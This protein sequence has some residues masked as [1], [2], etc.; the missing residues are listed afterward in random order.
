MLCLFKKP[1]YQRSRLPV[2]GRL[3]GNPCCFPS[4]M[5]ILRNHPT[6][7]RCRVLHERTVGFL[8]LSCFGFEPFDGR[9]W[10]CWTIDIEYAASHA[11]KRSPFRARSD[12]LLQS[13]H[14]FCKCKKFPSAWRIMVIISETMADLAALLSAR[15]YLFMNLPVRKTEV[16]VSYMI[17]T[18]FATPA[19]YRVIG[20]LKGKRNPRLRLVDI[21]LRLRA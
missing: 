20:W 7:Q 2:N 1:Q 4:L 11:T 3:R 15:E 14:H 6:V 5:T 8:V 12:L 13:I 9:P 17:G 10:P 21:R 16:T 19:N 18:S